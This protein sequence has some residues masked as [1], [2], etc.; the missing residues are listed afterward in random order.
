MSRSY[1]KNP[2][3]TDRPHGAKYWKRQANRRVRHYR[4]T[5]ANKKYRRLYCSW[6]I[7]DW[8]SRWDKREAIEDYRTSVYFYQ[9]VPHVVW[10]DYKTEQEFLDKEWAKYYKRK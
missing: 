10:D 1:K 9:G 7:H 2:I 8:I 3:Y 5:L 6:D 4:G